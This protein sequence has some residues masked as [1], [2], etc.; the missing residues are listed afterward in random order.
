MDS[1]N[2]TMGAAIGLT[3]VEVA[4][5]ANNVGLKNI[6][7][8]K[9]FFAGKL[10]LPRK[11]HGSKLYQCVVAPRCPPSVGDT[12][13]GAFPLWM[14]CYKAEK[15]PCE[16]AFRIPLANA[17]LRMSRLQGDNA[18]FL[19]GLLDSPASTFEACYFL[20]TGN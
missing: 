11:S 17:K 20:A 15:D 13:D 4:S 9:A 2:L 19:V 7:E 1:D 14:Y 5:A 3:A 10:T 18:A 8:S 16:E 6:L 12:H